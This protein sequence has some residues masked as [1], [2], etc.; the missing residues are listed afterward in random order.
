MCCW[1]LSKV[2]IDK[3]H[4]PH[5]FFVLNQQADTNLDNYMGDLN[6]LIDEIT[7]NEMYDK[8]L[9]TQFIKFKRENFIVLPNAFNMETRNYSNLYEGTV[10]RRIINHSFNEKCQDLGRMII[11]SIRDNRKTA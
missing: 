11:Q 1:A 4:P 9:I 8:S 3:S 6:R 2:K 10:Q 5:I 7:Q